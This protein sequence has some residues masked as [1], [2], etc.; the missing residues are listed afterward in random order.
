MFNRRWRTPSSLRQGYKVITSRLW[1]F[2]CCTI[3]S[4]SCEERLCSRDTAHKINCIQQC[5][6][7]WVSYRAFCPQT[8]VACCQWFSGPSLT[9]RNCCADSP[10]FMEVQVSWSR[11]V[12]IC[13]N[14][15]GLSASSVWDRLLCSP[16]VWETAVAKG[17]GW[18]QQLRS[19]S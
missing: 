4:F 1:C 12:F 11:E 8:M 10:P 14:T 7:C 17:E 15:L 16:R 19:Q 5:C 3:P 9:R 2:I 13:C 6:L 18:A